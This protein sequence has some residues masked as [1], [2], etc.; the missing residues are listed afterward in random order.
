MCGQVRSALMN[1]MLRS[2]TVVDR[3]SVLL[4]WAFGIALSAALIS[5]AVQTRHWP[6]MVN[7]PIMHYVNFL[8]S[9]GLR[10]YRDISDMNMPG[11]YLLE[12]FGMS[13]FGGGDAGWRVYDFFLLAVA[14]VAMVLI[15]RPYDWLAGLYAG[16]LFALRHGSE[17]P[18]FA[19]EREQEMAVLLLVACALLFAA[20]RGKRPA[21]AAGFG[22][23][24]WMAASIKP[25]LAPFALCC[26]VLLFLELRRRQLV[27]TRYLLWAAGGLLGAVAVTVFF[28]WRYDAFGPFLF[29]LRKVTPLY[30]A[31]NDPG[32]RFLVR[33]VAPDEWLP[34]AALGI[35]SLL[36]HRFWNWE[37]SVILLA[38]GCGL[39]S[40]FVQH[41]GFFYQRY[42][43][44]TTG[45]LLVSL[46]IFPARDVRKGR[47]L[48]C[49]AL[50]Y[51]IVFVIPK[52]L[53]E[54][55]Y[56]PQ[57][58][59]LTVA[60]ERDLSTL[61]RDNLQGEVQCFDVTFGCLNSLYHLGLIENTG[62]TGDLL[63]FPM[64]PNSATDYYRNLF[65]KLQAA[66]PADVI[67]VSNQD[68]VP[69]D[70]YM[71]L[72]RWPEFASYLQHDY[73]LAAERSFPYE[74]KF[75]GQPPAPLEFA[76][77]YRIYLRN[78]VRFPP[79]QVSPGSATV[80]RILQRTEGMGA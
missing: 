61:G 50:L 66:H 30:V 78:G 77:G 14:T 39:L 58:S 64:T 36:G 32:M 57:W 33:H 17:G 28:F 20:V 53:R 6:M 72:S 76:P 24:A 8:M 44:I 18:W 9:H 38:S 13:L 35:V 25:T 22:F 62:Y 10:P 7:A 29:I 16:G 37:Y 11:A 48:A 56:L 41:K 2:S 67:V 79:L 21:L 26:P 19:G 1:K 42:T 74:D 52:Y 69:V 68:I 55:P 75:K 40:Y 23:L 63:L 5:F 27:P 46:L 45:L 73:V 59:P 54:L 4:R 43:F 51:A 34:I 12:R 65:W 70:T 80:S 47:W 31:L 71:R 49:A 15:A 3:L 60:M